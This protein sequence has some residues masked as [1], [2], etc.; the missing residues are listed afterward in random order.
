MAATNGHGSRPASSRTLKPPPKNP[1]GST[2]SNGCANSKGLV[3]L[4]V[5]LVIFTVF[6]DV[7]FLTSKDLSLSKFNLR[8]RQRHNMGGHGKVS[9]HNPSYL[10]RM[11][12]KRKFAF[13]DENS[14][15][16]LP[17]LKTRNKTGP[18]SEQ[19]FGRAPVLK[20]FAQAGIPPLN[21]T[22]IETL[23]TWEQIVRVIGPRP[24]IGGLD[25]CEA[26][27]QTVPAVERMLG[28]SGMFNTG[29]NLVTHLLK[30]NCKIPE[31][32]EKY[33]ID[34]S[35]EAHGMRWQVPWGKHSPAKY[36]A[37][38]S[39]EMAKAINKEWIMPVV[40]IRHPYSWMHSM[41]KNGYTAKWPH[42]RKGQNCPNLKP[43]GQWNEV[44]TKFA[45]GRTEYSDSLAHLWN[46]WYKMYID[47]AKYPRLIVRLEDLMFHAEETTTQICTCVGGKI[48]SDRN[49]T[50][51]LDSAKA[52]SPG[53][54]KST[55]FI[56]AW[57]KYSKPMP[58]RGNFRPDD[59]EAAKEALNKDYMHMFHY[60]HPPPSNEQD[61]R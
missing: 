42:G 55:G 36:K 48:R 31:R 13:Q 20:V 51:I 29:T 7:Y 35:R 6:I 1:S 4:L 46:D 2:N 57:I 25:T 44:T 22:V 3:A 24:V 9:K 19:V 47:D 30:N 33:G 38:H 27:K 16:K 61:A 45:N 32:V 50:Y 15:H 12:S 23:P 5:S 34:A 18:P 11:T 39:T 14:Q 60:D 59:Y 53:H 26:F 58:P 21:N 40:T 54:D 10:S 41:C 43:R 17:V 56:Q 52:D 8:Y 37:E 49:F 28:S